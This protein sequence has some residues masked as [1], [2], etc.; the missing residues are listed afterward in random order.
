MADIG[1]LQQFISGP[2]AG[3]PSA[4]PIAK[5]VL[6]GR[7]V[8]NPD[9]ARPA[10]VHG[11]W[12][13]RRYVIAAVVFVPAGLLTLALGLTASQAGT[14]SFGVGLLVLG[15]LYALWTHNALRSIRLNK[16]LIE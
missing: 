9:D 6:L 2:L 14:N 1:R 11:S 10:M 16:A 4:R 15:T 13:A 8:D 7:R 12:A 3:T 5:S